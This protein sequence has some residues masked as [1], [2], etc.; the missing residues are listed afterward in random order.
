M[1]IMTSARNKK[2]R[3]LRP[4]IIALCTIHATRRIPGQRKTRKRQHEDKKKQAEAAE[5][6]NV[7]E[8]GRGGEA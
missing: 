5:L 2:T 1:P 6:Q 7:G 8:A 4:I 3:A